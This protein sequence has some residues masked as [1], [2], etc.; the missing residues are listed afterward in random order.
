MTNFSINKK[1]HRFGKILIGVIVL[2]V[3]IL[4]LNFFNSGIRN[5]FYI[6]SSP[7]EKTFWS[8]GESSSGFFGSILNAGTLAEENDK[9]KKENQKLIS[10][11]TSLQAIN[12]ANQAQSDVSLACQNQNFKLTLAGIIGLDGQDILSINKGFDDGISVGMPV[13]GQQNVLYGKIIQ[14]YKNYSQV[15][16][17]SNK[18]SVINAEIKQNEGQDKSNSGPVSNIEGVIKGSGNLS[19]F[20]DLIPIDS[21]ISQGDILITSSLEKTF[22]KNLLIG[23][24]TKVSKNDQKPFQQAEINPFFDLNNVD[25]LFVITNYKQPK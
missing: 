2:A 19:V 15:M 18:K 12:D 23:K 14:V 13:I 24:I 6:I 7:L 8:A 16:L 5:I 9:L 20:L 17:I 3:L 22:P 21:T 4:I 10:E 1:Q 11:V 25:N